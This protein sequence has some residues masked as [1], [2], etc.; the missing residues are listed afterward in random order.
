[1]RVLERATD[2]RADP[3]RAG[4]LGA[5]PQIVLCG[6]VVLA[7]IDRRAFLATALVAMVAAIAPAIAPAIVAATALARL[8]RLALLLRRALL[9]RPLLLGLPLRLRRTR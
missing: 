8:L 9:L 7:Q 4:V 1:M 2:T 5:R 3:R 6:D